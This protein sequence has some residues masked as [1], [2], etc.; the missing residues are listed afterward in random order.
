M[1]VEV[2]QVRITWYM[3]CAKLGLPLA[4]NKKLVGIFPVVVVQHPVARYSLV[5]GL[6]GW[7]QLLTWQT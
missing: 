3:T 7:A 6:P 5:V 4:R 2:W 1:E